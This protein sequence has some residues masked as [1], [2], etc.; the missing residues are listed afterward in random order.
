MPVDMISATTHSA[1]L[2]ILHYDSLIK[3]EQM[4]ITFVATPSNDDDSDSTRLR[5]Y[6]QRSVELQGSWRERA[7]A[8]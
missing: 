4:H 6:Y 2:G 5:F 7:T 1:R 8:L 3:K